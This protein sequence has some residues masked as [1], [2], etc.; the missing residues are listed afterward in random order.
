MTTSSEDSFLEKLKAR[1]EAHR[2]MAERNLE[3]SKRL[4]R[5]AIAQKA[6]AE[7]LAFVLIDYD[8][9]LKSGK[10]KEVANPGRRKKKKKVVKKKTAKV[11]PKKKEAQEHLH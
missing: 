8:S 2:K 7:S 10:L 4:E 1:I 5:Q 3:E 6:A 9:A 11:P